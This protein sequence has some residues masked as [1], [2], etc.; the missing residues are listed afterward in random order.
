MNQ[1]FDRIG[2]QMIEE[3]HED[4]G[5]AYKFLHDIHFTQVRKWNVC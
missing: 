3:R 1:T 4:E 5:L 2:A